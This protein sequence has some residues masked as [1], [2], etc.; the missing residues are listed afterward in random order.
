MPETAV[1]LRVLFLT[2]YGRLGA[3]SRQR[4]FLYL[5]ALNAAGIDGDLC[6]LLGDDY[7]R[8]LHSG[9]TTGITSILRAYARRLMLLLQARRYDLLW[10]EKEALPWLPAWAELALFRIAGTRIVVDYDDAVFHTYDQH[11]NGIVRTLLSLKIDRIMSAADLVIVG[12]AYLGLRAK[13]AGAHA[14]AEMPTVVDLKCYP[15]RRSAPA[16][17]QEPFTV[18]W[19]GSSLTSSYLEMLRPALAE[20]ARRLPL[21]VILVGAAEAALRGLPVERVTWSLETEATELVHFDV[22]LMPLP[23]R[24]WER[25]KCGYKLIQYMA[26][27]LP[28]VASP[29]GINREIVIS[30]ETGFLAETDA[31][32]LTSLSRLYHEPKLRQRMGAAG[33]RRVGANYSLAVTAPRMTDLFQRLGIS[34]AECWRPSATDQ[35]VATRR[36]ARQRGI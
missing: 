36:A 33:R 22:G 5:E 9:L 34:S 26:S 29:V 25:G 6:P 19:I 32:W 17:R 20:L 31:D 27:A 3:S 23:D 8:R 7:V 13:A 35:D 18:G 12:N 14:I 28:V 21:R 15:E 30:G 11:R 1:P 2:R 4:C 10:I 24:P 16:R